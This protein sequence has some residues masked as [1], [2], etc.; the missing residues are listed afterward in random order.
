M[1]EFRDS[2]GQLVLSLS[3]GSDEVTMQVLSTPEVLRGQGLLLRGAQITLA[4]YQYPTISLRN[5]YNALARSKDKSLSICLHGDMRIKDTQISTVKYSSDISIADTLFWV[6]QSIIKMLKCV[7]IIGIEN[8]PK[9]QMLYL[10]LYEVQK[11]RQV[12]ECVK[13]KEDSIYRIKEYIE[14]RK[15][16]TS[17]KLAMLRYLCEQTILS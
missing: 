10:T 2:T 11:L 4:S 9:I 12:T 7:D 17:K 6:Y 14:G 3:D 8:L 13:D 16:R 5:G 1:P 15:I